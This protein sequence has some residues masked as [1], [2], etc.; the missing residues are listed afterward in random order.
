VP[1][2][3]VDRF[4]R[5]V[6][7]SERTPD[8]PHDSLN[9]LIGLEQE[10]RGDRQTQRLG[11]LEVDDEFEFHGLLHGQVGGLRAF[12]DPVCIVGGTPPQRRHVGPVRHETAQFR[13]G[14]ELIDRRQLVLHRE[15]GDTLAVRKHER[16]GHDQ[17][18]IRSVTKDRH[19][20]GIEF[21]GG[22]HLDQADVDPEGLRSGLCDIDM[23][24]APWISRVL[25]DREV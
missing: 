11:G 24:G 4:E 6:L 21:G 20:G 7:Q 8:A 10:R 1:V 2:N 25:E 12:E 5:L 15:L 3:R 23:G 16:V 18:P 14:L 13:E 9:H 19:E 22:P 17:D